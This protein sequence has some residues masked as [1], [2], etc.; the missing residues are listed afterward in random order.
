MLFFGFVIHDP[1]GIWTQGSILK[2]WPSTNKAALL[3]CYF[4]NSSY[5]S[6]R[7][8]S[9]TQFRLATDEK[10]ITSIKSVTKD[11]KTPIHC[12]KNKSSITRTTLTTNSNPLK[13][14]NEPWQ[15]PLHHSFAYLLSSHV[16]F[17]C[18]ALVIHSFTRSS[19]R[20]APLIFP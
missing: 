1:I 13:C 3:S 17:A 7:C 4:W 6:R 10:L 16:G 12:N 20:F 9:F 5:N 19:A 18:F 8:H 11:R 14:F 2:R 15:T